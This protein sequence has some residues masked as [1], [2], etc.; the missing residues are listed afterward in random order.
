VY[1]VDVEDFPMEKCSRRNIDFIMVR[2]EVQKIVEEVRVG[3]DEALR[4]YSWE[5]DNADIED[6]RVE[7]RDIEKAYESTDPRVLN[8][9]KKAITNITV[10]HR[11]CSLKTT[12]VRDRHGEIGRVILPLDRIGIYVPAGSAVYPTVLI[13][14]AVPA[15]LAGVKQIAVVSPPTTSGDINPVV[16]ATAKVLGI[17]EVYR[18]GGPQAIAALAYGTE[19][20]APVDK[21]VGPGNTY[22]SA[23]K[24]LVCKDVSIDFPAGP[25][26][27]FVIADKNA[28]P[29]IIACDALAVTEHDEQSWFILASPSMDL[30]HRVMEEIESRIE[31][32]PKS[33]IVEE[34]LVNRGY[35][36]HV[37]ALKEAVELANEFAPEQLVLMVKRPKNLMK[38]VKNTGIIL[39]GNTPPAAVAYGGGPNGILPTGGASRNISCLGVEDFY[40]RITYQRLTRE[41]IRDI[42]EVVEV[43]SQV[44]GLPAS[45]ISIKERRG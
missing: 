7:E 23:A 44:E 42:S 18:I 37:S 11:T 38:Y 12:E 43:L 31:S 34:A 2:D 9:I 25:N 21:I 24:E 39:L 45:Y 15:K 22:V 4:R 19:S 13:M 5:L 30:L 27:L 3:G 36:V 33:E 8:A 29:G 10:F 28:D 14:A 26:E 6:I 35:C 32:T 20:V 40:K 1:L 17:R 16:L 41:G